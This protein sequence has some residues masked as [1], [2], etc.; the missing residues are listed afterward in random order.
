MPRTLSANIQAA[1]AASPSRVCHLLSFTVFGT[2]Y[3]FAEDQVVFQGNTYAPH[4][5]FD[6][7]IRLTE[8]LRLEPVRV[9]LQN[10][11][12]QT[13]QMLKTEQS[14]LQGVEATVQRL[15]LAANEA[16][17]LLRGR[18]GEIQLTE[19]D[20]A[21]TLEG[22]LDP[23]ATALPRRK[24]SNLCVWDFKDANCGY[25]NGVDPDDPQTGQPFLV[26]PKDFASCRARGREHRFP[27]FLHVTRDLTEAVEGQSHRAGP[28][29]DRTLSEALRP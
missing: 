8:Q 12:L 17:I 16:V 29:E 22:D 26:C 1:I 15:F 23:T 10:I 14:D 25:V 7:P 21:L 18:I 24:Y 3:Y 9:R 6:S 5:I 19:R 28:E 20:A 4:L 27:G 13:A 11:D 2:N